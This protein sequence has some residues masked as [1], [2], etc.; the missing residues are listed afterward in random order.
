LPK[1]D[2]TSLSNSSI[3]IVCGTWSQKNQSISV[4]T[5]T[6]TKGRGRIWSDSLSRQMNQN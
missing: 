6:K 4:C 2:Q 5:P 1:T 3:H